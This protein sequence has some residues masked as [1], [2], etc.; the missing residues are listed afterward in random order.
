MPTG[1]VCSRAYRD[2]ATGAGHPER[3]E[4]VE[5]VIAG[6]ERAGLLRDCRL[7][8]PRPASDAELLRCHTPLYLQRV[9]EDQ[10]AGLAQLSTGDTAIGPHSER[11]A[12][13]AA[14]GVLAAVDAVMAGRVRN[15]FAVVRPPGH[16]A[17]VSRGMGF[18][19][20]N[21][22]AI[23]ARHLQAVH[24]IE[25]VL[26]ADWDV[27]HGNGTQ[28]I[29]WTDPSVLFLSSHQ[30]PLYPGTG[31]RR[32]RGAGAGEGFTCNCPLPAGT[33]GRELLAAWREDLLPQAAAFAPDVVLVS[34]GFDSRAGDPLGDFRLEDG[35]FAALTELLLAIAADHARGRLVSTLE[36]GYDLAGVASAATA[37]VAALM[38]R[39]QEDRSLRA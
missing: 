37:H 21:N 28:E 32:E 33:S 23:A 11:T 3:P 31:S 24:G 13:L 34:A 17:G 1:I 12:R 14:G 27:H 29:F 25:R 15:A 10:R 20:Y 39:T 30:A 6:L 18:C 36:G 4:R 16:H 9:Q 2:H 22:V 7:I 38:G 8:P 35:D 26:I 5:A 19:L